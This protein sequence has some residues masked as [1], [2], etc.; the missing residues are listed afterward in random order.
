MNYCVERSWAFG[1]AQE[2][3][4]KQG[5]LVQALTFECCAAE[6]ARLHGG[7]LFQQCDRDGRR[8]CGEE[9]GL[10]SYAR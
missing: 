6:I 5:E 10:D 3:I 1:G 8:W 9:V 2:L 7:Q 4:S